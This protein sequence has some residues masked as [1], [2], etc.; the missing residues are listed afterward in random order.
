MSTCTRAEVLEWRV[1]MHKSLT[2]R[3]MSFTYGEMCTTYRRTEVTLR[4]N[5]VNWSLFPV[6]VSLT[7]PQVCFLCNRSYSQR[8]WYIHAN[9]SYICTGNSGLW[10]NADPRWR[11]EI[12]KKNTTY[13]QMSLAYGGKCRTYRE[14]REKNSAYR[15]TKLMCKGKSPM[16]RE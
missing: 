13:R 5:T 4:E 8:K 11:L 16:Y 12:S 6:Q 9:E 14:K 2:Y 3:Q 10:T 7:C 1:D 15:R